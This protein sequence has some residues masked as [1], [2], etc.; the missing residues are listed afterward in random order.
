MNLFIICLSTNWPTFQKRMIVKGFYVDAETWSLAYL[1]I[2]AAIRSVYTRETAGRL[3]IQRMFFTNAEETKAK[4]RRSRCIPVPRR[5]LTNIYSRFQPAQHA[6]VSLSLSL[7]FFLLASSID[8]VARPPLHLFP[9][10]VSDL[11]LR[12]G[13]QLAALTLRFAPPQRLDL[14]HRGDYRRRGNYLRFSTTPRF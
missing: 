12:P 9:L 13:Y 3:V 6:S 2:V 11:N 5:K 14:C 4:K 10:F 1:S 8:I 7:S